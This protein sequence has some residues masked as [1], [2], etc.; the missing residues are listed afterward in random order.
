MEAIVKKTVYFGDQ[1]EK[2]LM[3]ASYLFNVTTS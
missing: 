2:S 3:Q 1:T